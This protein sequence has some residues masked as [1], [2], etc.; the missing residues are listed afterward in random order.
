MV[1]DNHRQLRAAWRTINGTDA[2]DPRR[3][4]MLELFDAMPPG[5]ETRSRRELR[6]TF[7]DN[8]ERIVD[9]E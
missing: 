5:W 1:I 9:L 6:R 8:Y 4:R 7:R 3:G 2:D